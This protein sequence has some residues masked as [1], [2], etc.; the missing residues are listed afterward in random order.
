MGEG[1][2]TC[3]LSD[4]GWHI[5]LYADDVVMFLAPT[6]QDLVVANTI[7]QLFGAASVL[8]TNTDKCLISLIQCD[9]VR[10]ATVLNFF[11]GRLQAF[12][13]NDANIW[14]SAIDK[15]SAGIPTWKKRAMTKA[16]RTVLVKVKLSA[17]PIHNTI[18]VPL[19]KWAIDCIDKR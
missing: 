19:S 18:I 7:L 8:Q 5:Y 3:H 12:P 11:P 6:Q 10:T 4:E 15:I 17:I 2:F 1:D 9:L 13:C 16:D 14:D